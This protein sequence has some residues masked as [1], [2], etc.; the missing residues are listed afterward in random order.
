MTRIAVGLPTP[1]RIILDAVTNVVRHAASL[2]IL[3]RLT[4]AN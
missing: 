4:S 2:R 1:L 3:C